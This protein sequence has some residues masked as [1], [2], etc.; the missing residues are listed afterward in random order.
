ML[1]NSKKTVLDLSYS[2]ACMDFLESES[3]CHFELPPYINFDQILTEVDI[4]LKNK[5]LSDFYSQ[6]PEIV[7]N[8]N[9]TILHNKDGKYAWRPIQLIHPVLY[10]SLVHEITKKSNWSTICNRF[11]KFKK[12]KITCTSIPVPK[13]KNKKRTPKQILKW[14]EQAEQESIKMSLD[15]DYLLHTDIA[16]C[17]GS[18]YTHSVSWAI[19]GKDR[20]KENRNKKKLIGNIIDKHLR[21]M[22]YGQTNGIPQGSI[23]MDFIAEIVLGYIDYLLIETIQNS[24]ED[25]YIIRYRDDYRIFT[26]SIKDAEEIVKLLSE[27]L[28]DFGMTLNPQKTKPSA[29]M[30]KDSIKPDKLSWIRRK[31]ETKDL[32]KDLL[33]IHG[34]AM[35][36]PGSGSLIT[37]LQKY[38]KRLKPKKIKKNKKIKNIYQLINIITDIAYHN[39]RVYAVSTGILSKIISYISTKSEQIEIVEKIKKKF[40]KIP[41]TGHLDI[42]LQRVTIGFEGETEFNEPICK[43]VKNVNVAHAEPTYTSIWKSDWLKDSLKKKIDPKLIIDHKKL[44]QVTGRPITR[45]E[46]DTFFNY[47]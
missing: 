15:Y 7:E 26:N 29:Q 11:K 46:V 8:I 1:E 45:K 9:H 40:Q 23:L 3:Y 33:I 43:L 32:Q 20:A 6:K 25:Y 17:Y 24:I 41:N 36:F 12:D 2:K 30:I 39:P 31:Q 18:L 19:Y 44:K 22:S 37:V 28:I 34:F 13:S 47:Y 16:N 5:N 14:L 27:I 10:V 38:N 4:A 42:W 21:S 35:D